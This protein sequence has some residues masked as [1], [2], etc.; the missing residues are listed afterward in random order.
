[1]T[2]RGVVEVFA[3]DA[4]LMAAAA[5]TFATAARAA[6]AAR[7]RFVT[8]LSG[9]STPRKLFEL[10]ASERFAPSIDWDRV[11][12]CFVDERGVPPDA[13]ASNYRMTRETLLDRVAIPAAQMHRILSE[14]LPL[15]AAAAYE[16]TVRTLL[17]T[18]TGAPRP[19]PGARFD[20]VFLGM[21]A[22]G[23]T[24]S[25]FPGLHAVRESER[26]VVAEYVTEVAMWRIT[27]TPV[28]LNAAAEVVFL[29]SGADK[30]AMLHRVLEGPTDP[31]S[32]P[33]QIIA[34]QHGQL[35]WLVDAAAAASLERR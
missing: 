31:D 30:A 19:L 10:L 24:A 9:G 16:Q 1:M 35:R 17:D 8:A 22:N 12:V 25:F 11:E 20:L 23:H 26:W 6:I 32:L 3:D 15:V 33:A 5:T 13:E 18:P 21:G 28:V 34:P 4:A 27:L 2:M 14:D 29:V 7:G